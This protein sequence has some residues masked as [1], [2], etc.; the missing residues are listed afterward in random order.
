MLEG[1][2]VR[3][4]AELWEKAVLLGVKKEESEHSV[5]SVG[6][7]SKATNEVQEQRRK[8]NG[9]LTDRHYKIQAGDELVFL[10]KE[11]IPS[12]AKNGGSMTQP[13]R[14]KMR[15]SLRPVAG[16]PPERDAMVLICGWKSEW[17]DSGALRSVLWHVVS[18]VRHTTHLHFF[19][20]KSR[21]EFADIMK[22]MHKLSENNDTNEQQTLDVIPHYAEIKVQS[23]YKPRI[24]S[25][26]T[27][28][29]PSGNGKRNQ[30]NPPVVTVVH[31][32][33]ETSDFDTVKRVLRKPKVRD[34]K[35]ADREKRGTD[36]FREAII[37]PPPST[38]G[39]PAAADTFILNMML[40]MRQIHKERKMEPLHIVA[41]TAQDATSKVAMVPRDDGD[42][43]YLVIPDFVNPQAIKARVLCQALAFPQM[44]DILQDIFDDREAGSI[45]LLL[46]RVSVFLDVMFTEL[47]FNE[48]RKRVRDLQPQHVECDDNNSD[49]L[50]LGYLTTKEGLLLP[51]DDFDRQRQFELHDKL[52]VLTRK[53][54]TSHEY[55]RLVHEGREQARKKRGEYSMG[56]AERPSDAVLP[57]LVEEDEDDVEEALREF[58]RKSEPSGADVAFASALCR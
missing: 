22:D 33:G 49:D 41:E 45:R 52:I 7:N 23:K 9:M 47:S 27:L 31:V 8:N 14:S 46:V 55:E 53:A 2:T 43:G 18:D 5:K 57:F 25:S 48:V 28:R 13:Q 30:R 37:I 36:Q 17:D 54:E 38:D 40:M 1:K 51:P 50:C 6:P 44:T 16:H 35:L 26:W 42:G 19:N 20:C 56:M 4:A 24:P 11:F 21:G 29:A 12:F 39:D 32:Q 10:A 34:Y 3:E 15:N 58:A